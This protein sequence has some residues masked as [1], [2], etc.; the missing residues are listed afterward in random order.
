MDK[1]IN[2]A[3]S[4]FWGP[5][6]QHI[7]SN[8]AGQ[9]MYFLAET[10]RAIPEV[11]DVYFVSWN[12]DLTTIPK[13]L[14]LDKMGIPIYDYL[15][16]VEK[17]DLLIEGT[18]I[19]GQN[20][21]KAFR[22]HGAKVVSFRMGND[23]L[24]DQEAF[25]YNFNNGNARSFYGTRY[26]AIWVI[27]QLMNTNKPYLEIMTGAKVHQVPHVWNSF[28]VDEYVKY[29]NE[30]EKNYP[31]FMYQPKAKEKGQVVPRRMS[32][33]EPNRSLCKSC[34]VPIL[35]CEAAYKQEPESIE[36]VYACNTWDRKDGQ[37]FHNFIG[38]TKLVKDGVMSIEGRHLT[39]Y[40]LGRYTDIMV[41]SQWEVGLNYIYYEVLYGD[42]PL[43]H[44]SPF[45]RE[46]NVG[47]YYDQFDAYDGA[48]QLLEAIHH[49]DEHIDEHRKN[50]KAFLETLDPKYPEN[51]KAYGDLVRA[52]F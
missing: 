28:F 7:W 46:A 49:Y 14:E 2:V 16:V 24:M 15:D 23:F 32:I 41:S 3:I 50:N 19:V 40:F 18:L 30:N 29:L 31:G 10:L 9:N 51:V 27:P 25:L 22:N 1:K 43:V 8:G 12:N 21:E 26:D 52:L 34:Y 37:A 5:T 20:I 38:W 17:T 11:G 35:I 6:Y 33:M 45:L 36:H 4:F 47:Y 44:N 13:E 48:K 42:Y 39:P